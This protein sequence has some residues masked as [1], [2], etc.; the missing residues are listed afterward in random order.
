MSPEQGAGARSR[1]YRS[2]IF[3][4]GVVLYEMSTGR[5]PFT[6]NTV[7]ETID[8]HYAHASRSSDSRG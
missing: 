8:R 4:L 7:T 1:S 2:D 5:C 3:S 6:G